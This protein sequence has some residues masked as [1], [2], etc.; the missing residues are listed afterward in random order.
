MPRGENT[1]HIQ[2]YMD[3]EA[4]ESVNTHAKEIGYETVSDYV[5]DLIKANMEG[6]GKAVD[7]KIKR[8]APRAGDKESQSEE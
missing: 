2:V 6:Y 7:F 5:R 8:G 4:L 1:K 3:I